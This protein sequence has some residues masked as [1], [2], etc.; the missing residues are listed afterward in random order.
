VLSAFVVHRRSRGI[1]LATI[2]ADC[3]AIRC[4][5][6]YAHREGVIRRDLSAA[7]EY[8]LKYKLSTVPRSIAW[9]DVTRVLEGIDR[10]T[11]AGK[12]DFAMLMLLVTYGLRAGEIAALTLDDVDWKRERLRIPSRKAGNATAYPLSSAVGRAI[13]DYL[14]NGRP[15]TT[16]RRIFMRVIAPPQPLTARGLVTRAAFWLKQAGIRVPR[17]GAHTFRHTCVQR[18]VDSRVPY[19]TISGY[20]GHRSS[21]STGMYAKVDVESLRELAAGAETALR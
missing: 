17:S 18:L 7:I 10:R 5:L 12:R 1:A 8:P 9:E 19:N 3:N 13:I 15:A 2:A 16:D 11:A 14:K 21:A 6:R 4:L 20:V